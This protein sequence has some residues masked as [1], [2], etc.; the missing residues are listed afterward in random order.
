[1]TGTVKSVM[2]AYEMTFEFY[3]LS[4]CNYGILRANA[5]V[6][7]GSEV[8]NQDGTEIVANIVPSSASIKE[9]FDILSSD[10]TELTIKGSGF[11]YKKS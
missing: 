10:A 7:G 6:I 11:E 3:K 5:T 4:A 8:V 9:S 1:M 2:S